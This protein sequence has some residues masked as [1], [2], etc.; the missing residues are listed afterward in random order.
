MSQAFEMH[1]LFMVGVL[2]ALKEVTP[3]NREAMLRPVLRRAAG[4]ARV[5]ATLSDT[6][7]PY[8]AVLAHVGLDDQLR[9]VPPQPNA[10]LG[11]F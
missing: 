2:G 8:A 11:R 10:A 5:G 7:A 9:D 6:L 4:G 3:P 1:M